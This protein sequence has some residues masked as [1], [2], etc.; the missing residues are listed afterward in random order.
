M[1][2]FLTGMFFLVVTYPA[3][4]W[5][6]GSDELWKMTTRTDMPGMPMPEVIQ[7]VCLPKGEAY[8]PGNVPH[9]KNC[10]MTDIKVSGDKTTWKIHCPGREAMDGIGEVTRAANTMKGTMKLSSKDI[11]MT[12]VFS[13]KR[14]GTCQAK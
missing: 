3:Y 11:Q 12:Q 14:I 1:K 10:K 8:K 7:T 13:G 9:Q 6:A 4:V 2:G 5:A